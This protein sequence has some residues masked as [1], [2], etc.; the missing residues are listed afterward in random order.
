[1]EKEKKKETDWKRRENREEGYDRK[2]GTE[3]I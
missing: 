1:M 2:R 3:R